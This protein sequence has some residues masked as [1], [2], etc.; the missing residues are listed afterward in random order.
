MLYTNSSTERLIVSFFLATTL[1]AF[2]I[3]AV[4]FSLP[5]PSQINHSSMEIV[6]VQKKS[7]KKPDEANYL[8]QANQEGG[9]ENAEKIR[10]ATPIITPFPDVQSHV[11]ATPPEPKIAAATEVVEI[12]QLFSPEESDFKIDHQEE[13]DSPEIPTEYGNDL[14]TTQETDTIPTSTLVMEELQADIAS[15]QAELDDKF[16]D[17]AKRPREKF[18]NASTQESKYANYMDEWRRKVEEV[19]ND[20]YPDEIRQQALSGKLILTV[21]LNRDGTIKFVKIDESSGNDILDQAALKIVHLVAPFAAFPQEI[22]EETDILHI[23][24]TW[25]FIYNR[26]S[27]R[28]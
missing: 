20:N 10:P 11:V 25:N 9:G 17:Y 13:I 21:T 8:A 18:V 2:T 15:T 19:G 7:E 6:L 24:R 14:Q 23:T 5:K 26:L 22:R 16:E 28:K 1:H 27:S 4:G 3:S 12:E